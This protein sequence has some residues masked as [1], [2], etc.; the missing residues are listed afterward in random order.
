MPH[1]E[2]TCYKEVMNCKLEQ[3]ITNLWEQGATQISMTKN[4][5]SK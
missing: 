2:K 3:L 1:P 4:M 5:Q